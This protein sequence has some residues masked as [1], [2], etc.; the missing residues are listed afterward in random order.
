MLQ[1]HSSMALSGTK[2]VTVKLMKKAA[3]KL[4]DHTP[5]TYLLQA[6]N[7]GGAGSRN[8]PRNFSSP[9]KLCWA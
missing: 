7:Q 2:A 1:V 9:G 5:I 6:H 8:P 4:F 3:V